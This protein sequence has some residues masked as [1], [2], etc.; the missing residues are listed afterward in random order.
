MAEEQEEKKEGEAAPAPKKGRKGLFI[1]LGVV[2][3]LV[4][5]G[6]PT[7]LFLLKKPAPKVDEVSPDAA[8][9]H[10]EAH[11]KLEG[12]DDVEEFGED[13]EA[14]GAIV[15][16]DTFV[17][18]LSGGKFIRLQL[19]VEFATLDVPRKFYGRLVPMRDS[20]IRILTEKTPEDLETSKG[21]DALKL[22]IRSMM[23]EMLRREDVRRIY[24]T[25]FVI[26]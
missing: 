12:H 20:I 25:Q 16:F 23:N 8:A 1:I 24:F 5:V 9:D 10:D 21:K 17:V 2:I 11:G 4:A 22:Q 14:L 26:Q 3:L 13:E 7:A 15:P 19:Q 6:V 18:N